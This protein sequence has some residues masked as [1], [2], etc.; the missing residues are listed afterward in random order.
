MTNRCPLVEPGA[1]SEPT[2][3]ASA[4]RAILQRCRAPPYAQRAP[5][6]ALTTVT[7]GPATGPPR[8]AGCA[9]A[10]A[11][12]VSAAGP[13][14]P[15]ARSSTVRP[16]R[17]RSASRR[18]TAR[19]WGLIQA[20]GRAR[21]SGPSWRSGGGGGDRRAPHSS[22]SAS[23]RGAG[24]R[25]CSGGTAGAECIVHVGRGGRRGHR[26][27]RIRRCSEHVAVP[28]APLPRGEGVHLSRY[29]LAAAT[30]RRSSSA[31]RRGP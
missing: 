8:A 17:S 27:A 20:R 15:S 14:C 3:T 1:S 28:P 23:S 25:A 10:T 12:R 11:R 16:W 5:R 29:R 18:R 22:G 9:K 19:S 7:P 24:A 13:C 2:V 21:S 31:V 30:S 4:R 6:R 26:G